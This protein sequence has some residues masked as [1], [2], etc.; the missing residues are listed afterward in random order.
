[1][2]AGLEDL[3]SLPFTLDNCDDYEISSRS[4]DSLD[5][6]YS[7]SPLVDTPYLDWGKSNILL[8][9]Y[10]PNLLDA[11][12]E[13][14]H[15]SNDDSDVED[16]L[17]EEDT[18]RREWGYYDVGMFAELDEDLQELKEH[19]E[20]LDTYFLHPDEKVENIFA[21]QRKQLRIAQLLK[22]SQ[23]K[24]EQ[25]ELK[26]QT[27]YSQDCSLKEDHKLQSAAALAT[28][29]RPDD[30]WIKDI[31]NPGEVEQ[32][33]ESEVAGDNAENIQE[34][35]ITE[36]IIG[37]DQ[38]EIEVEE[39]QPKTPEIENSPESQRS[40]S[41]D[42]DL[43][44]HDI[45]ILQHYGKEEIPWHPG[46]VKRHKQ[47]FEKVVESSNSS[48]SSGSR[49]SSPS[50]LP[51]NSVLQD[52]L[53]CTSCPSDVISDDNTTKEDCQP[54]TPPAIPCTTERYNRPLS[55]YETEEI[56]LPAG[57]VQRTKQEIEERARYFFF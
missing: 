56:E 33:E 47:N 4:A 23:M 45:G 37:D 18:R 46:T 6:A 1:M 40:T 31:P 21:H 24:K 17:T 50:S 36:D 22:L 43:E 13:C 2:S 57:L 38:K 44:L 26:S 48:S 19:S 27:V 42:S 34:N 14:W 8:L 52:P 29:V 7:E 28:K 15:V 55:I 49:P 16:Y 41:A 12:A 51:D 20:E 5:D 11:Q 9:H 53:P 32:E 3:S 54:V 30:Y 25:D 10:K 39:L 35:L